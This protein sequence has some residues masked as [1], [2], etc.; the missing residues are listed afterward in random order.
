MCN[1]ALGTLKSSVIMNIFTSI[2]TAVFPFLLATAATAQPRVQLSLKDGRNVLLQLPSA[3]WKPSLPCRL[4][5]P[6]TQQYVEYPDTLISSLTL[7]TGNE[8]IDGCTRWETCRI[9]NPSL[10]LGKRHTELRLVGVAE[11]RKG[12]GVLY[13][14]TLV[15]RHNSQNSPTLWYGIR[16][17]GSEIVYP[18]IQDGR[19]WLRDLPLVL[20]KSHP[21]FVRAVRNYYQ[22][23]KHSVVEERTQQLLSRPSDIL[24][25]L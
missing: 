5:H 8:P 23:G 11:N 12:K 22:K 4:V 18:F 3:G 19:L 16:P 14:W 25:Q 13:R 10:I 7:E 6:E 21:A 17:E 20:G 1:F 24:D 2:A 15:S 9:A